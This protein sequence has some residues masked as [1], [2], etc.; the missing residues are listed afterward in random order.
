M[1]NPITGT[2]LTSEIKAM[3]SEEDLVEIKT[4]SHR[5]AVCAAGCMSAAMAEFNRFDAA[6][7]EALLC[8]SRAKGVVT[9]AVEYNATKYATD[10][11]QDV[12]GLAQDFKDDIQYVREDTRSAIHACKTGTEALN[13]RIDQLSK[14]IR[15]LL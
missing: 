12:L 2:D 11:A 6:L 13:S 9:Q 8:L 14:E 15:N 4:K 3:T 7:Q 5:D 1:I 10:I